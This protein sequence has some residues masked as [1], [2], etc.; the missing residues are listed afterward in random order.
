MKVIK[1]KN[2]GRRKKKDLTIKM[3]TQEM[4]VK[5]VVTKNQN[6]MKVSRT[7]N[8]MK[9]QRSRRGESMVT[10]NST[11]RDRRPLVTIKKPTKMNTTKNTSSMMIST[12]KA[13]IR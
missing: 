9:P 4:M 1:R 7:K 12:K 6:M 10:K 3:N 2:H 8:I 5:K 11:R 13:N